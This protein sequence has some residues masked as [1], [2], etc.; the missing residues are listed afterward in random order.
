MDLELRRAELDRFYVWRA[1]QAVRL[2]G[3]LQQL[4][5]AFA[6]GRG[7]E[8]FTESRYRRSPAE[9]AAAGPAGHRA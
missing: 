5:S 4:G 3:S 9:D 8:H 1:R 2:G 6:Y 7:H